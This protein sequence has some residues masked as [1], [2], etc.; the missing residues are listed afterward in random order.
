MHY[1]QTLIGY[2]FSETSSHIFLLYTIGFSYYLG[3][4]NFDGT[5]EAGFRLGAEPTRYLGIVAVDSYVYVVIND[6]SSHNSTIQ[7]ISNN[8]GNRSPG[9]TTIAEIPE[10]VNQ[11]SLTG[12]TFARNKFFVADRDQDILQCFSFEGTYQ[13]QFN[14]NLSYIEPDGTGADPI[15]LTFADN[16]IYVL[17]DDSEK[18]YPIRV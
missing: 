8:F 18:V 13:P 9:R 3:R 12:L 5:Q 2:T 4:F 16:Y 10:K 15:G 1:N 14:I 7:R 11:A 6:A 17:D